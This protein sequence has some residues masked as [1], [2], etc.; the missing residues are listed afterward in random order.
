MRRLNPGPVVVDKYTAAICKR[1]FLSALED[2]THPVYDSM[3]PK[4]TSV[5]EEHTNCSEDCFPCEWYSKHRLDGETCVE[6]D[7][8]ND[9]Y[10]GGICR[11]HYETEYIMG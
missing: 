3:I 9:R 4:F 11:E 1:N 8:D 2:I 6:D 7:C 10:R 5:M